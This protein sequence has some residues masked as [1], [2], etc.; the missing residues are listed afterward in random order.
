MIQEAMCKICSG[1]SR[2]FAT[3]KVMSKYDIRYYR[4]DLCG[5]IQT[6]EPYWL[7]EAY[8][9]PINQSDTGLLSR[10]I[11]LSKVTRN[12]L[13]GFHFSPTAK[14]LDYGGGYG[15][16]VRLMRDY[17]K[18]F[19]WWDPSCENLFAQGYEHREI[20]EGPYEL[21]TAFEVLEHSVDPIKDMEKMFA[22]APNVL[23]T[24]ECI[25]EHCP[26]P[27]QW[28]YYGMDHGQHIS[29]FSRKSLE[30]LAHRM[31]AQLYSRRSIHLMT[32]KKLFNPSFQMSCILARFIS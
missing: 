4:C 2:E 11:Y 18:N 23:L 15:I 27:G 30:I 28:W 26:K 29:L 5:F 13:E 8:C 31:G 7:Q 10:N 24:T 3:G 1:H 22:L 25:P 14:F 16:L 12:V 9:K 6:E 20:I 17:R 32:R 21:L 19:Y